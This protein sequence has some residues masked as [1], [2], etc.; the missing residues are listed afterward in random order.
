MS[1]IQ[2]IKDLEQYHFLLGGLF[3]A[4]TLAPGFLV[5]FHFKPDL[6]EKYDFFKLT[7]FS[8]SLTVPYVL[9][10][11]FAISALEALDVS[12]E[13]NHLAG[14][15]IACMSSL[16]VL[17]ISLLLAYFFRSSFKLFLLYVASLTFVSYGTYWLAAHEE[18]K[19]KAGAHGNA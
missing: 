2:D 5:I 3:F 10:H 1:Y 6:I 11:L 9:S 14:M 15:A 4:A 19:K 12:S 17:F 7:L 13:E 8:L 16:G 18:R